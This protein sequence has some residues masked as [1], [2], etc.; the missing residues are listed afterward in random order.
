MLSVDKCLTM[1]GLQAFAQVIVGSLGVEQKKRLT[2]AVELAAKVRSVPNMC[3]FTLSFVSIHSQSSSCS[4]TS[5]RLA[6]THKVLGPSYRSFVVSPKSGKPS[7]A[8][9]TNRLP[10]SSNPSTASCCF[11]REARPSTLV[12]WDTMQRH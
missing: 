5:Q 11:R 6:W 8:P 7:S 10:N 2:I 4:W 3:R 9:F 12:I 1:C